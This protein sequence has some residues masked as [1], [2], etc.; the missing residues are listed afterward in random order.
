M[1]R[2]PDFHSKWVGATVDCEGFYLRLGIGIS[3]SLYNVLVNRLM[4]DLL[5]CVRTYVTL[6]CS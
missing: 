1:H 3:V 5:T 2:G 6:Q 4:L